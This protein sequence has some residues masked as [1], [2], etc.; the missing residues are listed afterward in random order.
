MREFNKVMEAIILTM[1]P[2]ND[3]PVEDT[4]EGKGKKQKDKFTDTVDSFINKAFPNNAKEDETSIQSEFDVDTENTE[5]SGNTAT[6]EKVDDNTVKISYNGI[7]ISL[8]NEVIKQLQNSNIFDSE[9]SEENT[10]ESEGN[11][12]AFETE[13]SE[14]EDSEETEETEE[15][16][17]E[18]ED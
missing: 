4:D 9:D 18:T 1:E 10:E 3:T 14:S 8:P 12:E 16:E 6:I 17:E 11:E 7:E 15:D 2:S 13:E 5:E